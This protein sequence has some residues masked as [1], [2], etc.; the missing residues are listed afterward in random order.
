MSSKK[1]FTICL[2]SDDIC[3]TM[4]LLSQASEELVNALPDDVG[5]LTA[6]NMQTL[7][8]SIWLQMEAQKDSIEGRLHST[9]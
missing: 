3:M 1:K 5:S 4:A 2:T 9:H 7:A 6:R 8:D